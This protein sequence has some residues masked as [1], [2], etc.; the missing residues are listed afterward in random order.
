MD[1]EEKFLSKVQ[2]DPSGC[3]LWTGHVTDKGYGNF[4][5]RGKNISAH[6]F[7]Y[8]KYVGPLTELL[9][10]HKCDVRLCVNPD[11]LFAGTAQDNASDMVKKS[12]QAVGEKSG[13]SKLTEA[14]VIRV[15]V[16]CSVLGAKDVAK[17]F[18]V[19]KHAINCIASGRTWRTERVN[20]ARRLANEIHSLR[21]TQ[22][23]ERST[24]D[25]LKEVL[26]A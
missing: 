14:E 26:G 22:P 13:A 2:K 10:C 6:R 4:Y 11:H 24:R 1:I 9:V 23:R 25:R 12:R 8:T 19:T 7:S 5:F 3:W 16:L 20:K 17:L 21:G 15:V 18:A